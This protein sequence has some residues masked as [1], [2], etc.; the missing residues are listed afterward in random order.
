MAENAAKQN[1]EVVVDKAQSS[2][3][4]LWKRGLLASGWDS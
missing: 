3:S 2:W 4:D 1:S